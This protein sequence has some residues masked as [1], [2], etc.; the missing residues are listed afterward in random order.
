MVFFP[1]G[2]LWPAGEGLSH[3]R[4]RGARHERREQELFNLKKNLMV[5]EHTQRKIYL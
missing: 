3:T 5:I 2:S 4:S 1:L